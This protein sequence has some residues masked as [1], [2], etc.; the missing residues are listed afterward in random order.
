MCEAEG[1]W[2]FSGEI[3]VGPVAKR[4]V[5]AFVRVMEA[6]ARVYRRAVAK[7]SRAHLVRIEEIVIRIMEGL[8]CAHLQ[9]V[10]VPLEEILE[11]LRCSEARRRP[12]PAWNEYR[13]HS[14]YEAAVVNHRKGQMD[15]IWEWYVNKLAALRRFKSDEAIELKDE[16]D[17]AVK[18]N[19]PSAQ[20]EDGNAPVNYP[21]KVIRLDDGAADAV[22]G[23]GEPAARNE[24]YLGQVSQRYRGLYF[25]A[26]D[27][28]LER[29]AHLDR[30]RRRGG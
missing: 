3:D 7:V 5:D 6:L 11:F 30:R 25:A 18:L 8:I 23:C 2:R 29:A 19:E 28:R 14:A 20:G 15:D 10:K 17:A 21:V 26:E 24:P 1:S 27:E 4:Q 16:F 13:I 22:W 12:P 9:R